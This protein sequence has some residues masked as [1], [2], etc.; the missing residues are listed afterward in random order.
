[1][2]YNDNGTI[3]KIAV[4]AGD[5]LPIG[6]IVEVPGSTVP[7]GYSK[8]DDLSLEDVNEE[9]NI[10]KET[11]Q[12]KIK[13]LYNDINGTTGNVTL[14]DTISN[15]SYLEIYYGKEINKLNCTKFNI[16]ANN[17]YLVCFNNTTNDIGI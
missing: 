1:M 9:V 3:K 8:V 11:K 10:L 12:D 15:Y 17:G 7:D 4:K 16:S 6:T 5:T 2:N 14:N 13:I